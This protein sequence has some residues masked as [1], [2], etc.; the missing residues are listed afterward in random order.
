M[1]PTELKI[2][3]RVATPADVEP[4]Y[5]IHREA[6]RESVEATWGPWDEILINRLAS[7]SILT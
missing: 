6:M 4:M 7:K 5:P 2:E 1:T 3:L